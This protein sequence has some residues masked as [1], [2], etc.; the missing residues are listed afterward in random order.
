MKCSFMHKKWYNNNM[1]LGIIS[2]YIDDLTPCLKDNETGE[3][4]D[5][6]VIR[7]RRPSFLR[8][9][10]KRNGWYI[11]WA[12]IVNNSEVYALVIKGTVD[13]QGLVSIQ[14][15]AEAGALYVQWMCTAPQNNKQ[16]SV[17]P[18]YSGVGGHLFAIA[19]KKSIDYGF[20]GDIFGFAADQELL[21]HYCEKLGAV[22]VCMLHPYHFCIFE[23][24]MK[25]VMEVYNYEWTDEEL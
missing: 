20:K 6:E 7:I 2:V 18:K 9:Y 4:V 14:P 3:L 8:K 22:P 19:G 12:D 13:I 25:K 11:D 5:T 24:E 1:D 15:R 23:E 21:T 10:N 17:A 16:I